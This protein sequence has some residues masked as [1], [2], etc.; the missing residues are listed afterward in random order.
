MQQPYHYHKAVCQALVTHMKNWQKG[1]EDA[2]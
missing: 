2:A 1:S